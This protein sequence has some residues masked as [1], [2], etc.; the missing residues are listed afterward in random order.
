MFRMPSVEKSLTVPAILTR[1]EIILTIKGIKLHRRHIMGRYRYSLYQ[2]ILAEAIIGT[3]VIV[4]VVPTLHF[5]DSYQVCYGEG[6]CLGFFDS[7]RLLLIPFVYS[8][9]FV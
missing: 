3:R 1:I 8:S 7:L 6:K 2:L 9:L 5:R 4:S